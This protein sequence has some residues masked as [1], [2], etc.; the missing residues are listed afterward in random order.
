MRRGR[1][2]LV[3]IRFSIEVASTVSNAS[4][5]VRMADP[6][7]HRLNHSL[8]IYAPHLQY[9]IHYPF[10]RNLVIATSVNLGF[11]EWP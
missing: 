1:A 3:L 7:P 5:R 11:K 10:V 2:F 8:D 9:A 6:T 4:V